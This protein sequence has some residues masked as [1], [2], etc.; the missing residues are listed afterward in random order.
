MPPATV[1]ASPKIILGNYKGKKI[2]IFTGRIHRYEGYKTYEMNLMGLLAGLLGAQWLIVTNA[3]GGCLPGMTTGSLMLINDHINSIGSDYLRPMQS[4][5][6]LFPEDFFDTR[7]CYT[8]ETLQLARDAAKTCGVCIF[9]GAYFMA[10]GPTYETFIEAKGAERLGAGALGMSTVPEIMTATAIGLKVIAFSMISN[11]AS[12]LSP[13]ELNDDDVRDASK[14]AIPNLRSII[15]NIVERV[16]PDTARREKI[17]NHFKEESKEEQKAPA[18]LSITKPRLDIPTEADQTKA[19]SKVLDCA[20]QLPPLKLALI[21]YNE[22]SVEGLKGHFEKTHAFALREIEC[23]PPESLSYLS[24]MLV[25]AVKKSFT[26]V[27]VTN[28]KKSGLSAHESVI[29]ALLLK[30]LGVVYAIT[31]VITGTLESKCVENGSKVQGKLFKGV[32]SYGLRSGKDA[33][34]IPKPFVHYKAVQDMVK[35]VDLHLGVTENHRMI[36]NVFDGVS[37][38]SKLES[39]IT[40]RL[41]IS[42]FAV[43][44][45]TVVEALRSLDVNSFIVSQSRSLTVNSK[46]LGKDMGEFIE[47]V[48]TES[49]FKALEEVKRKYF[50][51]MQLIEQNYESA[52]KFAKSLHEKYCACL[53][54]DS[55]PK[56]VVVSWCAK[57]RMWSRTRR[58]SRSTPRPSPSFFK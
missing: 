8:E 7:Q 14:K 54:K 19:F 26:Y 57:G 34:L 49:L 2:A 10:S 25:L 24:G 29:L 39:I 37:S 41:D 22:C 11:P 53:L 50:A 12:F 28:V 48:A 13:C 43:T 16:Q 5:P 35:A 31:V 47:N 58:T 32:T 44:E 3:A 51:Q 38:P 4:D 33:I 45:I 23:F 52:E 1:H 15:L 40:Q 56:I 9:E 36:L 55:P 6:R 21:L 27:L 42:A 46:D 30:Q 18:L 20:K 17:L